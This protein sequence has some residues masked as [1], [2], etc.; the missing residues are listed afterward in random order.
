MRKSVKY[1]QLKKIID[2]VCMNKFN[3]NCTECNIRI[4]KFS[5]T[6]INTMIHYNICKHIHGCNRF[7]QQSNVF[8]VR[9]K[10]LF[11]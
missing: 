11:Q 6:C 8:T 9:E 3:V 4:H 1:F 10:E 7:F 5:C 2:P